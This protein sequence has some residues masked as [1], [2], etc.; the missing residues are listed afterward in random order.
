MVLQSMETEV[1]L[2]ITVY[3]D[4]IGTIFL[5]NNHT[6]C[7]QMKHMDI[8]YHFMHEKVE[9]GMVKIEFIKSEDAD[10]L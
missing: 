7:D 5:V 9:D 2:P 4:N 8:H 3:V 10:L 1:T 6:T